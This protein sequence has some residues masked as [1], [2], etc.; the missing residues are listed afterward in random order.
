MAKF[1]EVLP[2]LRE[3]KKVS[4]KC[5]LYGKFWKTNIPLD[6]LSSH[7]WFVVEEPKKHEIEKADVTIGTLGTVNNEILIRQDREKINEIIDW[8]SNHDEV[9][10]PRTLPNPLKPRY[11]E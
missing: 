7:D 1:E 3:G 11:G 8:I 10:M 4:H 9:K 5:D 2:A 6:C